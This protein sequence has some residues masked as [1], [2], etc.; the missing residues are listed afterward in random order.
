MEMELEALVSEIEALMASGQGR[1]DVVRRTVIY[2]EK[3]RGC[4]I[5]LISLRTYLRNK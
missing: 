4:L 3:G 2:L 5:F 1:R